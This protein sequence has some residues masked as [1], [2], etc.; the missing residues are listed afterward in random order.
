MKIEI[1]VVFMEKYIFVTHLPCASCAKRLIQI[2][3]VRKVFFL[4]DYRKREGVQLL[5]QVGIEVFKIE[6]DEVVKVEE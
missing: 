1:K 6:N 4:E 2:G 3:N 5:T